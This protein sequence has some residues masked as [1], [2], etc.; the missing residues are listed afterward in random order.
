MTLHKLIRG[1]KTLAGCA[2]LALSAIVPVKAQSPAEHWRVTRDSSDP[3]T[4]VTGIRATS[5]GHLI[6]VGTLSKPDGTSGISVS[7]L[8]VLDGSTVWRSE[9]KVTKLPAFASVRDFAVDPSG[10]AYVLCY[11]SKGTVIAKF[12]SSGKLAWKKNLNKST[13]RA[14]TIDSQGN[15]AVFYLAGTL[16]AGFSSNVT[17]YSS[18]KGGVLW[19]AVVATPRPRMSAPDVRDMEFDASGNLIVALAN[20]DDIPSRCIKLEAPK[21][22]LVWQREFNASNGQDLGIDQIAVAPDGGV[23]VHA[24]RAVDA[25]YQLGITAKLSGT[26]GSNVWSS[27][28][29]TTASLLHVGFDSEGHLD[30]VYRTSNLS[31]AQLVISKSDGDTGNAIWSVQ[32]PGAQPPN[33]SLVSVGSGPN[34]EI[35]LLTNA[36]TEAWVHFLSPSGQ[37]LWAGANRPE[38]LLLS[39]D[40]PYQTGMMNSKQIAV[41]EDGVAI[42]CRRSNTTNRQ[43]DFA[44]Y[45]TPVP[46]QLVVRT[47]TAE[48]WVSGTPYHLGEVRLPLYDYFPVIL[49]NAGQGDLVLSNFRIYDTRYFDSARGYEF[50]VEGNGASQVLEPGGEMQLVI[51]FRPKEAGACTARLELDSTDPNAP[52]ISIP[53]SGTGLTAQSLVQPNDANTGTAQLLQN[54]EAVDEAGDVVSSDA[55]VDG[56][57]GTPLLLKYAFHPGADSLPLVTIEKSAESDEEWLRVEYLQRR[58]AEFTYRAVGSSEPLGPYQPI[59]FDEVLVTPVDS[60]WERVIGWRLQDSDS[61]EREFVRLEVAN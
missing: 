16:K 1:L 36:G 58:N 15:P 7:K 53:L 47:S 6:A 12:L 11:H 35:A 39:V 29:N 24:S 30:R 34:G 23:V 60:D 48:D 59:D 57:D 38:D 51:R 54:R 43:Q 18:A 21:G 28:Q 37:L 56:D 10:N 19:K 40:V 8:R 27:E 52:S 61:P 32:N 20:S 26:D 41:L 50:H 44:K 31:N 5:D 33:Y 42:A 13:A 14:I 17:K 46:G 49:Q 9:L 45:G 4:G 2:C 25:F 22:R 3:T 55:V